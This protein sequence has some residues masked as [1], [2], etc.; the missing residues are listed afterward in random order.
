MSCGQFYI[1]AA[2]I[3]MLLGEGTANGQNWPFG[4]SDAS[5]Q[6]LED[7]STLCKANAKGM[8]PG[9]NFL[10]TIFSEEDSNTGQI[11][12]GQILDDSPNGSLTGQAVVA[13]VDRQLGVPFQVIRYYAE[14]EIQYELVLTPPANRS[15]SGSI[16]YGLGGPVIDDNQ[17]LGEVP[18]FEIDLLMQN[19]HPTL[20]CTVVVSDRGTTLG[21]F[22]VGPK[23]TR[24][25]R[26][27]YAGRNNPDVQVRMNCGTS[28]GSESGNVEV[29][30]DP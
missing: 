22:S 27:R 13:H 29:F 2:T 20:P 25:V 9:I 18:Y 21:A 15:V 10:L 28:R 4:F 8:P 17:D 3:L 14:V 30:V 23:M 1:F 6:E 16:S 11:N 24:K 26:K 12:I 7:G 19:D 5:I